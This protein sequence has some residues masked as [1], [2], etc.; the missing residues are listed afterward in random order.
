MP[1]V[2]GSHTAELR[3][4]RDERHHRV[5]QPLGQGPRDAPM[6]QRSRP[7]RLDWTPA[8]LG[9]VRTENRTMMTLPNDCPRVELIPN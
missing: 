9:F 2:P 1:T 4:A 8:R 3:H 7:R 6:R 5:L